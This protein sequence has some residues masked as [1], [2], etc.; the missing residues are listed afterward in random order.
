ME[1]LEGSMWSSADYGVE[2]KRI[3][4]QFRFTIFL[5]LDWYAKWMAT[6]SKQAK[7]H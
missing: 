6:I 3:S 5:F 4:I 2:I 7:K 1:S